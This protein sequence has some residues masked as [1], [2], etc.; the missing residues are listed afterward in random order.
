[1][2]EQIDSLNR[3]VIEYL[4]EVSNPEK[5]RLS[6]RWDRNNDYE[7]YGLSA[8]DYSALYSVFDPR[9]KS[10]TLAQLLDLTDIWSA[11][12]NRTLIHLGVHLYSQIVQ[13]SKLS[14]EEFHRLDSFADHLQGWGN[15]DSLCSGVTQHLLVQYPE[16]TVSLLRR[17]NSSSNPMKRRA[18]VVTFTRKIA[19]SGNYTDLALELCENLIW[20]EEDL[21]RKGV[22]WALKDSMRADRSKIIEYV[23][24]LRRRGVS[25]VIT[26]YAIRDLEGDERQEVLAM[27]PHTS[28]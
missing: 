21:V 16:A 27:K 20:D 26:L 19:E 9:F 12:G 28:E 5:M 7:T 24:E 10:L 6:K 18:S 1:M 11:T 25:S 22:G 4:E 13:E 8:A 15:T 3:E 2:S 17:W 14:P 23:K